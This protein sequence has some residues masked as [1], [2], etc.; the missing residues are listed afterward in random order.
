[1]TKR[2]FFLVGKPDMHADHFLVLGEGKLAD[3]APKAPVAEGAEVQLELVEVDRH[4]ASAAVGKVDGYDVCVADAASLVGKRVKVRVVRA[5]D[6]VEYAMLVRAAKKSPEPLTAEAE[7]EKP[8]RKPPA[9]RGS[10][11]ELEV[12]AEEAVDVVEPVAE[13]DEEPS[14]EEPSEDAAAPAAPAKKKTRRGSRGGR[15]RKKPA[16]AADAAAESET[17]K[18]VTIHLPSDD[19]GLPEEPEEKAAEP[20]AEAAASENG[21]TPAKKRTRRG[22][23]GGKNRRK[24][25]AAAAAAAATNGDEPMQVAEQEPETEAE[26]EAELE[27]VAAEHEVWDYVPMSEWGDELEG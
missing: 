14:E 8:T 26:Q 4:D 3:L 7:A 12:A 10:T 24:R 22:S 19:L 9:R 17:E 27:E 11:A 20:A 16:A 18:K 6:G 21:A 15:N 2:R 13:E 1:M 23:R 25:T 5:L